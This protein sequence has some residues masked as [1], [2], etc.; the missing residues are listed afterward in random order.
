MVCRI[1]GCENKVAAWG[2]CKMHY[3]RWKR[4]NAEPCTVDGCDKPQTAKGLCQACYMRH[5]TNG[6]TD[7]KYD[8]RT[9]HPLHKT[10]S[11]I[12]QRCTI[13]SAGNY[14][15][16]GGRGI[17]VCDRWKNDF[18]AFVEDLGTK[19]S[20]WHSIERLDH[21]GHYE[22]GNCCWAT[23]REQSRN[24]RVTR[25]NKALASEIKRRYLDG[26]KCFEIAKDIGA[27]YQTVRSVIIGQSWKEVKP[28]IPT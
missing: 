10:W 15:Y 27:H 6:T 25:L 24:K 11:S 28:I 4:E 5:R 3:Y 19:P 13:P 8:G 9:K 26:E 2:M 21:N 16:Y 17:K 18:W 12:I 7:R 20:P 14:R 1:A 22:P 23:E